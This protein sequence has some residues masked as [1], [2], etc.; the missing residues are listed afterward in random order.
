MSAARETPSAILTVPIL[1]LSRAYLSR[2]QPDDLV[3]AV[4]RA[5]CDVFG[6]GEVGEAVL[7][8]G[9]DRDFMP[10]ADAATALVR[11]TDGRE[12]LRAE[13]SEV[14]KAMKALG[15]SSTILMDGEA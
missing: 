13:R 10:L 9:A 4:C 15:A 5:I 7:T 3:M 11:A 6:A 12:D 14:L 8:A 1:G 2:L